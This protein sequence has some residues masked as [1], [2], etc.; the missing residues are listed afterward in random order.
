MCEERPG[1]Q[2][3]ASSSGRALLALDD[4]RPRRPSE[5]YRPVE[6]EP[7]TRASWQGVALSGVFLIAIAL[8]LAGMILRL[9][10]KFMLVEN[11]VLA[12]RPELTLDR[13]ALAEFPAKFEAYFNDHFGYRQ[14]LIHWLN[15][16]KVAGLGVSPSP[17]VILGQDGWLFHGGLYLDYFRAVE[18]FTPSETRN[19]A[20]ASGV[21]PGLARR[22]RYSLSRRFCTK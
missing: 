14:R 19:V 4:K 7:A 11:R 3:V 6:D 1:T 15:I 21:A 20:A 16:I 22:P 2:P 10:S 5:I 8:P 18:P 13:A 17:N 9:D 12:S